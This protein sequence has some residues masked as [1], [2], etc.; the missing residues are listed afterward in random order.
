MSEITE[1]Q[2]KLDTVS[3]LTSMILTESK[4]ALYYFLQ[5]I[6]TNNDTVNDI[7]EDLHNI[8]PENKLIIDLIHYFVKNRNKYD[9][10]SSN[11]DGYTLLYLLFWYL[12][13]WG[14]LFP[15]WARDD[16]SDDN[17]FIF[18]NPNEDIDYD[19]AMTS[20]GYAVV[21]NNIIQTQEEL[22]YY[23]ERPYLVLYEKKYFTKH[24]RNIFI[25]FKK[26][27]KILL[28]DK[29]INILKEPHKPCWST[30]IGDPE[31]IGWLNKRI[32]KKVIQELPNVKNSPMKSLY[33]ISKKN[34]KKE[35]VSK[36]D[37][38]L[39]ENKTTKNKYRQY[40]N[41]VKQNTN[42]RRHSSPNSPL[43]YNSKSKTIK[44]MTN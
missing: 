12:D 38:L 20:S 3:T 16:I 32:S 18:F 31:I 37:F 13:W 2:K 41:V 8:S 17:P 30:E 7:Y 1:L 40:L 19:E 35:F 33:D 5:N 29:K 4:E 36:K 39:H 28:H 10:N 11:D 14:S 22:D 42:I 24:L 43:F 25:K 44:R 6:F 26:Y 21:V 34:T 15:L 27:I 23:L 9:I